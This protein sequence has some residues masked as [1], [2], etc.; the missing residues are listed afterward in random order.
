MKLKNNN[1]DL[2]KFFSLSLNLL[3]IAGVDAKFKKINPQFE[4]LLGYTEEELL[5]I[6]FIDLVHP[7][8][9]EKTIEAVSELSMGK[10]VVNFENRYLKKNGDLLD[11]RWTAA[12]DASEGKIYAV[13]VDIT[14]QKREQFFK[15]QINKIREMYIK[16]Q[17]N[18][19]DFWDKTLD[20]ILKITESEYGFISEIKHS[21]QGI[22][23]I[24]TFSITDISWNEETR[25]LY[26]E[27][28]KDGLEFHN[29]NTLFGEVV[30]TGEVMLTNNPVS[31]PKSVGIPNG[32][33]ML[34]SFL[35]V[36]LHYA[37][38]FVGMIGVANKKD[39]YDQK[40]YESLKE[41]FHTIASIVHAYLLERDLL[42]AGQLNSLYKDAID[43]SSI[44]SITDP[45]G[46]I[47]HVNE[48][49]EKI[50]GYSKEELIGSDHRMINSGKMPKYFIEN[51]WKTILSGNTWKGEICNRAK[52]GSEYWVDSTI[53]P[54]KNHRGDIDSFISIRRDITLEREQKKLEQAFQKAKQA[55]EAKS[56]FLSTMSH[57]IRTPLNGV[58]GM[59]DLLQTTNLTS[60]QRE[61]VNTITNSG[62]TLLTIINDILDF[63]KIEAGKITLDINECDFGKFSRELI[64]PLILS[65]KEK[66][67]N[68][69]FSSNVYTNF[70]YID[71]GRV[72]Q[73][74]TNLIS[75]AI[76]FTENGE[77]NLK[78][79]QNN[80]G[81]KNCEII[82][83]VSDTGIGIENEYLDQI[84]TPFSQAHKFFKQS[85]EGTGLGLSICKKLVEA[86]GGDISVSSQLNKGSKFQVRLLTKIGKL[87]NKI[88][89]ENKSYKDPYFDMEKIGRKKILIAEDNPTNQFV[90]SCY[91]SKMGHDYSVV[92]NGSEVLSVLEKGDYDLVLMDCQMPLMSGY[93]ATRLIRQSRKKF[94]DIPIIALTANAI[95]GDDKRCFESGMNGYLTKPLTK[96]ELEAE[97][98]KY[99][100]AEI[101]IDKNKLTQLRDQEFGGDFNIFERTIN[102]FVDSSKIQINELILALENGNLKSAKFLAHTMKSSAKLVGAFRLSEL[103]SSIE[104]RNIQYKIPVELVETVQNTY[105]KTIAELMNYLSEEEVIDKAG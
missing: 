63:S 52:N 13:G 39:G 92:G 17:K 70:V 22:P 93:E 12:P 97:L 94:K 89:I 55:T 86:M 23:Y 75:N 9:R 21:P 79:Q 58:V 87:K 69:N 11:I 105:K 51:L 33:P 50:S 91:V 60:E 10:D 31:H 64:K 2:E 90:I 28:S 72:G 32:H 80:I 102:T 5:T 98:I 57:E 104:D 6:P 62:K 34:N 48:M 77:I 41:T 99:F 95:K 83:D 44:V 18:S 26:D 71:E 4:K 100:S 16:S 61:I 81:N 101:F 42:D 25:N 67:I 29:L 96:N 8:D 36:P 47:T 19:N 40:L 30:K 82:I 103:L 38:K 53:V 56:E 7:D 14:E 49:F 54:F 43:K 88:E 3:C 1:N 24:K 68:L 59:T 66:G 78:I 46:K 20:V 65:A 76:K 27:K 84:F 73:I 35:G 85:I 37:G 45:A 15:E 74:I